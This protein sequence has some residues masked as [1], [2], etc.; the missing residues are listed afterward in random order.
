MAAAHSSVGPEEEPE[1]PHGKVI[2][3][4]TPS[5]E[6]RLYSDLYAEYGHPAV[7]KAKV[8]YAYGIAG[9]GVYVMLVTTSPIIFCAAAG[10][11]AVV[12]GAY[13]LTNTG[14]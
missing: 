1:K 5:D 11:V 2:P 9:V 14:S 6:L 8:L 13:I 3:S 10:L 12:G 4:I 7:V